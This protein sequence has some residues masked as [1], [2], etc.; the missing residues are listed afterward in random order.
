M[1]P[2]GSM[3]EQRGLFDTV[4]TVL[5]AT[6]PWRYFQVK[7]RGVDRG[8][9]RLVLPAGD[10]RPHDRPI[11]LVQARARSKPD[12]PE[13]PAFSYFIVLGATA[14]VWSQPLPGHQIRPRG[15]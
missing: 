1:T 14:S 12:D 4:H 8:G 3:S 5:P 6:Q 10:I 7:V 2:S 9:H 13:R 15:R 11:F